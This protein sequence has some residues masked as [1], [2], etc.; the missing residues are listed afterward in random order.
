MGNMMC[1]RGIIYIQMKK[2]H[3]RITKQFEIETKHSF[4]T[5]A[6][7]IYANLK[8]YDMNDTQFECEGIT[9]LEAESQLHLEESS[10]NHTPAAKRSCVR[11]NVVP[12]G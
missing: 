6:L 1:G 9:S 2:L 5:L 3:I 4:V 11:Q 8:W 10:S 12:T 7:R